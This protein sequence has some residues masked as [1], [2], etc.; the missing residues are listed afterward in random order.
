MGEPTSD[1]MA[2]Y[3]RHRL[4]EADVLATYRVLRGETFVGTYVSNWE[5]TRSRMPSVR[6]IICPSQLDQQLH[7]KLSRIVE[8][9]E[10]Q[11]WKGFLPDGSSWKFYANLNEEH[12]I[13]DSGLCTIVDFD[14]FRISE[15]LREYASRL[16]VSITITMVR[17]M[18]DNTDTSYR[19][20]ICQ[21]YV[22]RSFTDQVHYLIPS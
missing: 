18:L 7:A 11:V 14:V 6:Q 4:T 19:T 1:K 22:I 9:L 17:G 5:S 12:E 16:G 21:N 2:A 15:Q 3:L 10:G 20:L 13:G 8:R